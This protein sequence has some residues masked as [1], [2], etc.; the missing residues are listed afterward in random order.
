[1]PHLPKYNYSDIAVLGMA[2]EY[3]W[4]RRVSLLGIYNRESNS[5][6]ADAGVMRVNGYLGSNFV[7]PIEVFG[8]NA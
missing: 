5:S 7:V 6:L 4:Y 8:P 3:G 2:D 1:M